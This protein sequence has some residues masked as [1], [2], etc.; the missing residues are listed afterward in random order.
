[1]TKAGRIGLGALV[2]AASGLTVA[3][4]PRTLFDT[5]TAEVTTGRIA[6]HVVATG[7][8]GA[9]TTIDVGMPLTNAPQ[10]PIICRIASDLRELRLVIGERPSDIP[11]IRPGDVV[12]FTLADHGT[13]SYRATVSNVSQ[14]IVADVA[15]SDQ[16]LRP[17]MRV[18]VT[19]AEAS[20]DDAIR[21][22]TGALSFEPPPEA[23]AIVD[24]NGLELSAEGEPLEEGMH[25]VWRYDHG[26]LAPVAVRL[27]LSA[28]GWAEL[29]DGALQPGDELATGVI[30][31]R[32]SWLRTT[33]FP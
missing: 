3:A 6:A 31:R 16:G 1:M 22:P 17:G 14:T 15:N 21:I 26:R 32:T 27:G 19:F 7:T 29:R 24:A 18:A 8:L 10:A 13:K 4:W 2:L 20:R 5:Q 30:A 9:V 25:E 11:D 23:A 12:T 28:N 33:L